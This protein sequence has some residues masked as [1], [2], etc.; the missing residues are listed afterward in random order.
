MSDHVVRQDGPG[1]RLIFSEIFNVAVPFIDRHLDEGR[2]QKIAIRTNLGI[3]VSY[4]QL[5]INVNRSANALLD[6]GLGRGD[7][8]IMV[9]KDCAEFYYCFWG[10]IKV[11]IIPIPVNTL[12]RS[13]DYRFIIADSECRAVIYSPEFAAEVEPALEELSLEESSG[14]PAQA[15]TTE[16]EADSLQAMIATAQT[17]VEV[18]QTRAEDDC[19]W[20]YTSGS[21]GN[22]KGTIHRHRDM[23]VTSQHYAVETLGIVESDVCFSS[24]KLF[25]AYGLG[26]G[27]TFPLWV[28]GTAILDDARPTPDSTFTTLRKFRPSL[29]FGV[30]TLYMTLLQ[31][32]QT[33]QFDTTS[34][35]YC[36]SAGESLPGGILKQW[37]DQT[38]LDILDG[39]GSTETLN[40]FISNRAGDIRPDCSGRLVPGYQARI[41]GG[42]N[43]PVA[44]GESGQLMIKG[45]S[46]A[47][48]YWNNPEKTAAHMVGEWLN[49]GDTYFQDEAGYYHYCGRN[50]DMIKV[51]GIWCS[52][53][54]IEAK[55]M[56]HNAVLETAVIGRAD[57]AG[58]VK[59]EAYVVLK[60]A[61]TQTRPLADELTQHCKSSLAPYKYP[62]WF[63]FVDEL[64]KTATGKIQR[65]KL[66]ARM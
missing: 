9:I 36:V 52:P 60:Q 1:T 23:A 45:D 26:N 51:G 10:A 56:E 61:S 40:T 25:F 38:G 22:P 46:I 62:R 3:E 24:A 39:I 11:G 35:R 48:G 20:L 57:D 5:Q 64:P 16:G 28:G 8:L 31:S 34:I 41:L 32:M 66:R 4:S 54:E 18:V 49:T 29:Y 14:T 37:R 44:T 15:I 7:H 13:G 21:T 27:M 17:E 58:L 53:V 43:R 33:T 19:F 50:D 63:Q 65:Y 47:R 30:P 12:L 6:L 59:P 55:L 2:G 42:D